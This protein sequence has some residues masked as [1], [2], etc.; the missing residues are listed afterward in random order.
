ME[1]YAKVS[2]WIRI[3]TRMYADDDLQDKLPFVRHRSCCSNFHILTFR[4]DDRVP[5]EG[6]LRDA[7]RDIDSW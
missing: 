2:E 3:L 6:M 7:C 1:I 5:R 4:A